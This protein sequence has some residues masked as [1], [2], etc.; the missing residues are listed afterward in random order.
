[1]FFEIAQP[2]FLKGI[3]FFLAPPVAKF[4]CVQY[5][6]SYFHVVLLCKALSSSN[7]LTKLFQVNWRFVFRSHP[8]YI[9]AVTGACQLCDC[10]PADYVRNRKW[11]PYRAAI[12]FEA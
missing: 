3:Q 5:K 12:E 8:G 1:M 11:P 7:P 2:V 6:L 10:G 4:E 9:T